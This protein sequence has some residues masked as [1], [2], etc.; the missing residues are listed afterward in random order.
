M[1][2]AEIPLELQRPDPRVFSTIK[3]NLAVAFPEFRFTVYVVLVC[4]CAGD[5]D[6][7]PS[8]LSM[9]I[10]L[11]KFGEIVTRSEFDGFVIVGLKK[12]AVLLT[13][14]IVFAPYVIVW[15]VNAN[16]KNRLVVSSS[17]ESFLHDIIR[18][19]EE[20]KMVVRNLFMFPRF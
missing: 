7:E 8:R 18:S 14:T 11:V 20:S 5:P 15:F 1:Q 13:K 16:N 17:F 12:F 3:S 19:N 9:E 10:E 6:S 4:D 2:P